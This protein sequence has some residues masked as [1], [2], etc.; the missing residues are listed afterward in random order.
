MGSEISSFCNC[1]DN[2]FLSKYE[3]ITKPVEIPSTPSG[4]INKFSLHKSLERVKQKYESTE[5]RKNRVK[6]IPIPTITDIQESDQ[7]FSNEPV[8]INYE[9][10]TYVGHMINGLKNGKGKYTFKNGNIYD[11]EYKNDKMN[12]YGIYEDMEFIYEGYF[13][14]DKKHG[15]GSEVN[16]TNTYR[17]EGEWKDNLKNGLGKEILPDKS[18]YEGTYLNGKKNGKGKLYLSNGSIY[19]GELKN[20]KL[21]GHGTLKWSDDKIYIGQ[22]QDSCLSGFG[23]FQNKNKLYKGR[24][25][26]KVGY[27][28]N[29]KKH[30]YGINH[31]LVNS[32]HVIGEWEE[33]LL[34]GLA[35]YFSD[36]QKKE[37][38][39][40]MKD[41]KLIKRVTEANE[42]EQFRE[43]DEYK[44][45]VNIYQIIKSK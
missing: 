23:V 7:I 11:G 45:L 44:N 20:D 21:E 2:K 1:A 30:G 9:D 3:H 15:Q 10:D 37:Q 28:L 42:V 43:T 18:R 35:I 29:D 26:L 38:I 39:W 32:T 27:F 24:I 22:W 36:I 40:L 31:D 8:T 12:G 41:N 4:D 6:N 19:D 17:Y 5:L 13:L 25:Y 16:K 14:N 34:Q 33:N